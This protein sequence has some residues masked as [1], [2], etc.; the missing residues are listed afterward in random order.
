MP[1]YLAAGLSHISS[2]SAARVSSRSRSAPPGR[3]GCPAAVVEGKGRIE[4]GASVAV[5]ADHDHPGIA[6]AN[7]LKMMLPIA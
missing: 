1:N 5:S 3:Q 6:L 4:Q 7:H 2:P